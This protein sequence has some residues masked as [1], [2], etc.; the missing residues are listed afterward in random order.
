MPWVPYRH[1]PAKVRRRIQAIVV[2]GVH[3]LLIH[4]QV[5]TR[6]EIA[7][8]PRTE[9]PTSTSSSRNFVSL[10]HPSNIILFFEAAIER[11]KL[12]RASK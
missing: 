6:V 9:T 1:F 8:N 11:Y 7:P 4:L 2:N 5:S 12:T 10:T 3:S